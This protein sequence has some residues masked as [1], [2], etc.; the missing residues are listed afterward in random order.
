MHN[1]IKFVLSNWT[2]NFFKSV[3]NRSLILHI[4]WYFI[5]SWQSGAQLEGEEGGRV[6]TAFFVVT[7]ICGFLVTSFPPHFPK[8]NRSTLFEIIKISSTQPW[9]YYPISALEI[10]GWAPANCLIYIYWY[11]VSK[12]HSYIWENC[13]YLKHYFTTKDLASQCLPWH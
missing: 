1:K 8:P 5:S 4:L 9:Y 7:L 2:F 11:K 13:I 10:S 6:A 3:V 12:Q